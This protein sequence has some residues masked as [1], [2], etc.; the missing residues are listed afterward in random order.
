[1]SEGLHDCILVTGASSGLGAEFARQLAPL[2]RRMVLVARRRER[3]TAL[4]EELRA[5]VPHLE[6]GSYPADLA[7]R[8]QRSELIRRLVG[9][10]WAPSLLINNAGLGDYGEFA[11]SDWAKVEQML[12]VNMT[13]LTHLTHGFLPGMM[14]REQGGVINV[15]SLAS[16][17]PIP[18]FAAYAATKAYVTS[19]SEALRIEVREHGVSVLAVCPGP[20]RT[21]F[22]E[23]ARREGGRGMS[24]DLREVFYT[25][26]GEV[27]AE[28]IAAFHR[29]R[30]RVY[31]GWK[32]ALAAA[33]IALLPIG[34]LRLFL[35]SRP[36]RVEE[37]QD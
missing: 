22:G 6:L 3:L 30:A 27:V 12:E 16:I 21:E 18:D 29:D 35:A 7:D 8:M 31:P 32:I 26:P 2:A 37:A 9:T 5:L 13:A 23:Q 10:E 24:D 36:R 19:F 14:A 28:S 1:M 15:S 20:V 4:E 33:G 17:L 11:S 34:L 25:E